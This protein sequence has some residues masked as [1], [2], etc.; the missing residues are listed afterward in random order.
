[1]DNIRIDRNTTTQE[2]SHKYYLRVEKGHQI[3]HKQMCKTMT[4]PTY[5]E[6]DPENIPLPKKQ[7]QSQKP[8]CSTNVPIQSWNNKLATIGNQ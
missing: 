5:N 6:D 4:K 8:T 2:L 1:M 7:N 3:R